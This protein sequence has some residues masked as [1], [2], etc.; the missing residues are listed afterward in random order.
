MSTHQIDSIW[1]GSALGAGRVSAGIS[2][3][4]DP[5]YLIEPELAALLARGFHEGLLDSGAVGFDDFSSLF[6]APALSVGVFIECFEGAL[7]V[8]GD[9]L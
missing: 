9:D 5:E 8:I 6:A 3:Q 1:P 4:I 2:K 7:G